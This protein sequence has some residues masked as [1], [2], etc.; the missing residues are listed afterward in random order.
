MES[1]KLLDH[2]FYKEQPDNL[3]SWTLQKYMYDFNGLY[4]F[5]LLCKFINASHK[6]NVFFWNIWQKYKESNHDGSLCHKELIIKE[7]Q[8]FT[9]DQDMKYFTEQSPQEYLNSIILQK[10]FDEFADLVQRYV[11][12]AVR[13][14]ELLRKAGFTQTSS[15]NIYFSKLK[16]DSNFTKQR[17]EEN[18]FDYR[19]RT[20][21]YIAA[22]VVSGEWR[23]SKIEA[24]TANVNL[25]LNELYLDFVECFSDLN[26]D[27]D[28]KKS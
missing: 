18:F 28:K 19:L 3:I 23:M 7:L 17:T 8:F 24:F 12:E 26:K 9:E 27:S 21:D 22:K 2:P 11:S 20:Q 13:R 5:V 6:M 15:L 1:S 25:V 4:F 10:E 16:K 14:E